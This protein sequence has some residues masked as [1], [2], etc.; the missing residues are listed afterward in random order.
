VRIIINFIFLGK[1]DP[2]IKMIMEV[3]KKDLK[4]EMFRIKIL[5]AMNKKKEFEYLEK[6]CLEYEV[7]FDTEMKDYFLDYYLY[8]KSCGDDK[9]K[10][11]YA[12]LFVVS[13]YIRK[14]WA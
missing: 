4:K 13:N 9:Q 3:E 11:T 14:Y 1:V 2:T 8:F 10:A 5:S 12:A 7:D 6:L